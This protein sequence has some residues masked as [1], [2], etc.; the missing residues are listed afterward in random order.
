MNDEGT[1][2][3]RFTR[4]LSVVLL[5][6]L[7]ATA[8]LAQT[9]RTAV[10]ANDAIQ[11]TRL[12]TDQRANVVLQG[13]NVDGLGVVNLELREAQVFAPGARLVVSDGRQERVLPRPLTRFMRGTI[14]GN[15]RTI[16]ALSITSDGVI[17]GLMTE[18]IRKWELRRNPGTLTLEGVS[19]QAANAQG[20]N[21]GF[22]C[23][24]D[25]LVE[26]PLMQQLRQ[27]LQAPQNMSV[28]R[29]LPAGQLYRATIA[30]E[31]DFEFYQ[32]MGSNTTT[33]NN[34]IGNLF[35]YISAIYENDTQT[36]LTVGDIFLWSTASDPWVENG[37]TWCRLA[38]FGKYWKNNRSGVTRSLAHFLSGAGLGG[39]IAWMDTM[40]MG[41]Q[42]VNSN[43]GCASVGNEY[44]FGGFG[45]SANLNGVINTSSGP[46]WDA[47][48]VAHELGHNFS[49][50]HTHCY[51]GVA[52]NANPVDGCY[53]GEGGSG[54]Y[55][56]SQGIPGIGTLIGGSSS[57]RQGTIMSYCHLLSGGMN[58]IAGTFGKNH[59]YGV[60]ANRVSD[61][62][63]TRVAQIASTNQACLPVISTVTS[64][65]QF[66]SASVS[67]AENVSGG[68]VTIQVT[69]SD[70]TGTASVNYATSNGTATAGSDYT[71]ASGTLNFAAGV[72]TASF[73]VTITDDTAVESSETINLALSSPVNLTLGTQNTATVTITDNDVALPTVQLSA[74]TVSVAENGGT[75]TITVTRSSGT[76][77]ST[78]NYATA[79]GSASAGSDYTA[80]SGTVSFAAG[81]TSRTF[82]VPIT[83]DTAVESNETFTVGL[84]SPSG[85]TLGAVTSATVT[86]TDNDTAPAGTVQFDKAAYTVDEDAGTVTVVVTRSSTVGNVSVNYAS[87]AAT[88]TAGADFTTTSGTLSFASGSATANIVVPIV[89][90][91][92][93]ELKETFKLTLSSPVGATL[94]TRKVATVAINDN[95]PGNAVIQ[96]E[97][98]GYSVTEGTARVT[99]RV[100]RSNGNGTATVNFATANITA[101]AGSDYAARS[102]TLSFAPGVTSM[103]I[104]VTI[105]NNTV[106]EPVET[107]RV[108]LS[109]PTGGTLG[110]TATATVTITDND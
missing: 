19:P 49:S 72:A 10:L 32:V 15:S 59:I 101:L 54:C 98:A 53:N 102:G 82:T 103:V 108:V 31:T 91:S 60:A 23:G 52:G 5:C 106:A 87:T 36:R 88:A 9:S 94:G 26:A 45:V 96:F 90:D 43:T 80:S 110:A 44:V 75:V 4:W 78:V 95:D 89:N 38:E 35:N 17:S 71:A 58:N 77:S 55:S 41:A 46:A 100:T 7:T 30:I 104:N 56:G 25:N 64:T 21:Q 66:S 107:F 69:R 57:N 29:E 3:N 51:G 39:G 22:T 61:K 83:D 74:S 47:T 92:V 105:T 84:S 34:Y 11:L 12:Y 18:G 13:V 67:V 24:N 79:N 93:G 37:G 65:V 73:Q 42:T 99:L 62:M 28:P 68:Q 20:P 6:G 50:P 70:T 85:A 97:T 1:A 109:A 40:C 14:N 63:S 2:V 76:G 27:Q 81:Q 86:I 8:T 48:V 33:A 16:V